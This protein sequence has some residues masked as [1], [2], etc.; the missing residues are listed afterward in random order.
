M[1]RRTFVGTLIVTLLAA[2]LQAGV[3]QPPNVARIG[4]VCYL[5]CDIVPAPFRKGLG[6]LGYGEGKNLAFELRS[7]EGKADR[8]PALAAA[9][10]ALKVDVIYIPGGTNAVLAAK[11]ATSTIPIVFGTV[12]DPVRSGLVSSLARPGGNLTGGSRFRLPI[13][14]RSDSTC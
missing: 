2:P 3:Q 11:A 12:A 9:L 8:L 13:W 5:T 1:D 4:V 7:A 6:Q 10:V 14:A